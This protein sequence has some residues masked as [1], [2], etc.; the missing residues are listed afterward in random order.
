MGPDDGILLNFPHRHSSRPDA[1][2][3]S[4]QCPACKTMYKVVADQLRV[5]EGWVRCG[6]CAGIFDA[7]QNLTELAAG[8]SATAKEDPAPTGS[9][10]Q[11]PGDAVPE[12]IDT[13]AGVQAPLARQAH[14]E[15]DVILAP[16]Q[17]LDG[18]AKPSF[19]IQSPALS[20]V[21]GSWARGIWL[22][23]LL[24]CFS[25]LTGQ[26][27][28]KERDRVTARAPALAPIIEGL[29]AWAQCSLTPLQRIEAVV[30]ESSAFKR[31]EDGNYHLQ[32]VVRNVASH[33]IAMPAIELTLTD[34]Q[35][36]A[37]IRRV[38]LPQ[39][40]DP[41][42][43]TMAADS[44]WTA[45]MLLSVATGAETSQVSGYKLVAFYP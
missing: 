45:S 41:F 33:A 15:A 22:L 12:S 28:H 24:L 19:L 16:P 7:R 14:T 39:D 13:Q 17:P 9:L 3:L 42:A 37:L 26:V 40:F 25:A 6:R 20:A 23:L 5:A 29:C 10:V 36:G 11:P 21:E 4:T 2:L 34:S 30:I 38:L 31:T 35:D 32:F 27:L 8:P 1:M 43:P 18:P 44:D